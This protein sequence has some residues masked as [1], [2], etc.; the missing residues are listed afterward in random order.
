MN[1]KN[2]LS[3][4][5]SNNI[6]PNITNDQ[7]QVYAETLIKFTLDMFLT[8]KNKIPRLR[9]LLKYKVVQYIRSILNQFILHHTTNIWDKHLVEKQDLTEDTIIKLIDEDSKLSKSIKQLIPLKDINNEDH[10]SIYNFIIRLI[11]IFHVA[12][13]PFAFHK[14]LL[15]VSIN[16]CGDVTLESIDEHGVANTFQKSDGK[17]YKEQA[18]FNTIFTI[19]KEQVPNY[20]HVLIGEFSK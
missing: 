9:K 4:I 11:Y 18:M 12:L 1:D 16:K 3:F 10:I 5:Q 13:T 17:L 20:K 15:T 8:G 6:V 2:L 7:L 14:E 19:T